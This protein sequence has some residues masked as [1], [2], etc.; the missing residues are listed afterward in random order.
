MAHL[1]I[2][3]I[4][5]YPADLAGYGFPFD[6]AHLAHIKRM[7]AAYEYLQK[8]PLKASDRL[9]KIR[10]FLA[11]VLSD[12]TLQ[13]CVKR[14]KEKVKHFD[15]LRA[16]MR[17]AAPDGK[18]GLNDDGGEVDMPKIKTELEK[19][20]ELKELKQAASK[21]IGYRKL[22]EQIEKYKDR[23]F[24]DGI[25]I[26][27]EKG[28]RQRIQPEPTNNICEQSF[29]EDKRGVRKRTGCKSMSRIFKTMIAETPYVKNLNNPK[30]LKVILNG[31]AT[32]AERF[33]EINSAQVRTA[34]KNHDEDQDKLR[35]CVKK[36]IASDHLL[37]NIIEAL[38]GRNSQKEMA[39]A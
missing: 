20:A 27:N 38:M 23:L 2:E 30:Y 39:T 36:A 6:R 24:T 17:L 32:L 34:M 5:D 31:K 8:T 12:S 3:W 11:E 25:E 16:I 7:E 37:Q 19:F 35:P 15:Q 9:I 18:D 22:V 28:V 4:Q 14:L 1:L 13:Q 33:A 10:D 26:V 21:D 29:R